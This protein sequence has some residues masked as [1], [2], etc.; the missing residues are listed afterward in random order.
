MKIM[1]KTCVLVLSLLAL[2]ST[3]NAQKIAHVNTD[4]LVYELA[5]K[6]SIEA[7]LQKKSAEYEALY[8]NLT[9]EYEMHDATLKRMEKDP[10]AS[11][12]VKDLQRSKVAEAYQRAL[13]FEQDASE[14]LQNYQQEL[15]KPIVER[16]KTAITE[17]AKE[18][19]YG[20]VINDQ[21]LLVSPPADDLTPIV[22]K[23]LGL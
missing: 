6:D 16:V 13:K 21:V 19:G 15:Y 23:K 18:K 22:R 11:T 17:V 10:N 12:I 8:T 4:S 7:K 20:Y 14:E 1:M 5:V 2:S 3:A 9:T